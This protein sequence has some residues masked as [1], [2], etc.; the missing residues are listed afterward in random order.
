M[1]DYIVV[2]TI[3]TFRHRFVVH[4]DDVRKLNTEIEPTDK[5]L[6]EWACDCVTCEEFEN[7]F[8]QLHLGEQ[9]IDTFEMSE[10]EVITLFDQDNDYLKGWSR[11]KKLEWIRK[12]LKPVEENQVPYESYIS[13]LYKD[14]EKEIDEQTK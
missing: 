6:I 1:N 14:L 11:E 4:K 5:N 8:S 2:T 3:S 12:Q 13:K 7:E 10:D 9:I